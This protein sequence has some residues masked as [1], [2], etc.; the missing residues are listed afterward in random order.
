MSLFI[1]W[2]T[3]DTPDPDGLA[4][5][6]TEALGYEVLDDESGSSG[7]REIL[8]GG[9][10]GPRILLF[11]VHDTKTVKNRLHFDIRS[12][13]RDAEVERLLA[14][15]ATKVDIGQ[16]PDASWVVMADPEGNEFCI[17]RPDR[18][19]EKEIRKSW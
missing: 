5:F 1:D 17:L 3:I 9:D 15:G 8:I 13:D 7:E 18:D 14:L 6:W 19:E 10:G 12:D 11:E 2:I 4:R 16:K